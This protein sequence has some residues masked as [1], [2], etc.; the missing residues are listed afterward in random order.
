MNKTPKGESEKVEY[1]VT[2]LSERE[3]TTYAKI[4]QPI[5]QVIISYVGADLGPRT[6]RIDKEDY[7]EEAVK[8][9]IRADIEKRLKEEPKTFKV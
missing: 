1:A 6:I 5:K 9:L 3:I 4:G 8:A 2:I 7:S